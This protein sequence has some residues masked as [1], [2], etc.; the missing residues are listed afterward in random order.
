M[1]RG[2]SNDNVLVINRD[3]SL[4]NLLRNNNWINAKDN[5]ILN[6][7]DYEI[8]YN[9]NIEENTAFASQL[10]YDTLLQ[11]NGRLNIKYGLFTDKSG[12]CH[13]EELSKS[14]NIIYGK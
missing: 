9:E 10:T 11:I 8:S 7:E 14:I 3:D 12:Y 1:S 13:K 4:I 2:N 5:E 6:F